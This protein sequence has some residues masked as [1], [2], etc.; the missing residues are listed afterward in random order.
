VS[1]DPTQPLKTESGRTTPT[2]SGDRILIALLIGALAVTAVVV[3]L[4]L[5]GS[6]EIAR[7]SPSPS[8][9][10]TA[11]PSAPA[12]EPS[13]EP[14]PLA[15]PSFPAEDPVFITP[16]PSVSLAPAPAP[17]S[18]VHLWRWTAEHLRG[19]NG[20]VATFACP[21]GGPP[22]DADLVRY[23]VWGSNPYTDDSSVCRAGVHAGVIT[24]EEGG[25]VTVSILPGM[26]WYPPTYA[27]GIQTSFWASWIGSYEVLVP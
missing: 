24:E 12:A 19:Q 17:D 6:D 13:G 15:S 8:A 26:S 25:E 16:D 21:P 1:V 18:S 22:V 7:E 20:A 9:E 5:A 14:D 23:A 27:N 11:V 2:G 4:N 3:L 10:P